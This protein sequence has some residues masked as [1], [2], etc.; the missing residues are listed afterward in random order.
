MNWSSGLSIN[1]SLI[2]LASMRLR[3]YFTYHHSINYCPT[4]LFP[5]L[6][7]VNPTFCASEFVMD[8]ICRRYA[9]ES[10][11]EYESRVYETCEPVIEFQEATELYDVW[12]V[13]KFNISI[14]SWLLWFRPGM[15]YS[16]LTTEEIISLIL[17]S[18][19]WWARV[20]SSD[21]I[22]LML[23]HLRACASHYHEHRSLGELRDGLDAPFAWIV[24]DSSSNSEPSLS[25][26]L[27]NISLFLPLFLINR[28]QT[29]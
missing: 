12:K 29:N 7:P 21:I 14:S 24:L 23:G 13:V 8:A 6:D 4:I 19:V 26:R 11:D 22:I 15:S 9:L 1:R 17:F 28:S 5:L 18:C 2:H 25:K 27:V 10:W 16:V 3:V 20:F